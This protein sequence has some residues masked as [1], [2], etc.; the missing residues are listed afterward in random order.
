MPEE[1][2]RI[3]ADHIS[4][5][6]FAPTELSRTN[7][8]REGIP[9]EKIFVTGNTVVDAVFENREIAKKKTTVVNSMG[10][11]P[12]NYFLVTAHRAENVDVKENLENI[13]SG[14]SR[15]SA[16]Y[17]CPV[18]FP[19]HPRTRKMM[20]EFGIAADGITII[21]PA[22]YMDFM[23]LEG[24]A[25]LILTDSGGVQEEAC[26]LGVPCVTLRENTERPE[27]IDVGG[28][29]LAGTSA[30]RIVRAAGKMLESSRKW[31]NPYGDGRAGERIV[32]ICCDGIA[33]KTGR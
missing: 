20:K 14:L 16:L 19:M 6:L 15:L 21:Q 8:L 29:L 18:I 23:Q 5:Y 9:D 1:I 26:I 11:S 24:Q 25:R 17:Q 10:L 31:E 22:G 13:I 27:T 32:R 2:N 12:H 3:V 7:L 4:D 33:G 28:N 30:E